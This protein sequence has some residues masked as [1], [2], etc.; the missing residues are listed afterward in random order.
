MK[1]PF[2]MKMDQIGKL[3]GRITVVVAVVISVI[4]LARD[5]PISEMFIWGIRH[6]GCRNTGSPSSHSHGISRYWSFQNGKKKCSLEK[7]GISRNPRIQ[8]TVI[9]SDKTGTFDRRKNECSKSIRLRHFH[10]RNIGVE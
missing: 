7:S 4:G 10:G 8:L 9:C 2:Q 5:Y 3:L 6:S 1:T